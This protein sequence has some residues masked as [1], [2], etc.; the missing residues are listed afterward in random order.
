MKIILAGYNLDRH[1]TDKLREE[2][3][4]ATPETMSAAYARISR[5][6]APVNELR[7]KAIMDVSKAR[8]SNEI[9]VFGLGH[10]SVAEHAVFN[11]DIIGISRL[12][13]EAI[14]AHRLNSYTEKSQRYIT[15][16]KDFVIPREIK[17][18]GLENEF[19]EFVSARFADYSRLL[20]KL[21]EYFFAIY[22]DARE[23][24]SDRRDLEGLAKEDARYILPLAVTSQFGMTLNAR[25]LEYMIRSLAQEDLTEIKDIANKLYDLSYE[26]APSLIKYVEPKKYNPRHFKTLMKGTESS[27]EKTD[28]DETVNLISP[29]KDSER[30][31]IAGLLSNL[32]IAWTEAYETASEMTGDE[33]KE[34]IRKRLE[35]M[36]PWDKAPKEFELADITFEVIV[37]SSCFAQLKRHRM[38]TILPSRYNTAL[39]ITI[40]RSIEETGMVKTLENGARE[41]S[42]LYD[43]IK[44]HSGAAADYALLNAHRRRVIVKMNARELYHFSRLR[45]DE[46]AQWDIRELAGKMMN[47]AK[48]EMPALFLLACGKHEFDEKY[49]SVYT[50]DKK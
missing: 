31:I 29:Y 12:A 32:G 14:Q 30:R 35:H 42:E 25:N 36:E 46:H 40:P 16:G 24:K 33:K 47:I 50:D 3:D 48:K 28:K 6:P 41:A 9:I 39:G 21:T 1:F 45:E 37:S 26:R 19:R 2:S 5:D 8:K 10:S 15:I 22:P 34:L 4:A 44:K 18:A 13:V 43:R 23:K 38:A 17:E 11:F 20:E 27:K 49:Q 7:R